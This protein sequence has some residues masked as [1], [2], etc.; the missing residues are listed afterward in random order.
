MA[1][2]HLK[3][4]EASEERRTG[5][6][7]LIFHSL[8]QLLAFQT[9][10][11]T[12]LAAVLAVPAGLAHVLLASRGTAITTANLKSVLF[13]WQGALLLCVGFVAI[14]L[15]VVVDLFAHIYFCNELLEG[16]PDGAWRKTLRALRQAFAAMPRFLTPHGIVMLL[17][18]VFLVPLVG[19]GFSVGLTRNLYVPRFIMEVVTKTPLYLGAYLAVILVALIYGVLHIFSLHAVLLDRRTPRE[20]RGDSRRLMHGNVRQLLTALVRVFLCELAAIAVVALLLFVIYLCLANKGE[21]LPQG[22]RIDFDGIASGTHAVTEL[23]A[24]VVSYRFF[25]IAGVMLA[26]LVLAA[27]TLLSNSAAILVA[28]HLYR[29]LAS[30]EPAKEAQ[31]PLVARRR[32][33]FFGFVGVLAVLAFI[34]VV[35]FGLALAFDELFYRNEPVAVVAHRLGGTAAPENSLEG[36]E[37]AIEQSCSGAETD[38]QRTSDGHYIINH[39]DTFLRLAGDGRAPQEMTLDEVKQL[40]NIEAAFPG[41]ELEIP[42]IEEVLDASTGRITLFIEL[43]GKTADRQMVDDIVEI[44]R[45]RDAVDDVVLISL[46]YDAI[47]YAETTYPEFETGLL[48]FA[49][50]GDLSLL[51]ADLLI[52]EEE[53][54]TYDNVILAHQAGKKVGVW[55]VNTQEAMERFLE[56]DVDLVITDKMEMAQQV[57]EQIDGR[58]DLDVVMSRILAS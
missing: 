51:K 5:I 50:Y 7:G 55:T 22:Y 33:L 24:R 29:C 57:Q 58:S 30:E 26:Q 2:K 11:K 43:K 25:C 19:V 39:D 47:A 40:R 31:Y 41:K 54:A 15:Y 49:G 4:Q 17:Y 46:N 56:S 6:I 37:I 52:M 44:V 35:A 21:G 16:S 53:M 27:L 8:G 38:I 9:I 14:L 23:D 3:L 36:L 48:F 45:A 12:I 20:A 32:H 13:S 10:N 34:V 42:T 1:A 18:V 28:T